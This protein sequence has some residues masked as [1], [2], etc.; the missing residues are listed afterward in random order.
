MQ[1][2][3]GLAR[4]RRGPHRQQLPRQQLRQQPRARARWPRRCAAAAAAPADQQQQ[5][6]GAASD[7]A[8]LPV[9]VISGFLGAGK[10]TL[11]RHLLSNTGGQ[12]VAVLVN[13]MAALNVDARLLADAAATGAARVVQAGGPP[14]LVALSNGCICCTIR[15]DLVREVRALAAQ[16][17]FDCLVIEST[18]ISLPMPVAATFAAGGDGDGG[19]SGDDPGAAAL[20]GLAG[21]ARL[22]TLVTVV[23][24]Q[25]FVADVLAAD[26]LAE[27]SLQADDGDER[28]VADLLVEQVEFAD[29]LL[30]NKTDLLTPHEQQQ[31][32][33]LLRK[34]NPGARVLLAERGRVPAAEVLRTGAFSLERAQAAAGWLQEINAFEARQRAA[35]AG[36][37]GG[38]HGDCSHDHGHAHEGSHAH[39]HAAH[40]GHAHDA[41]DPH[42]GEAARF[43]ISSFVYYAQR[44]FHPGRLLDRALSATW[45]GVLRSKGFFWL[46]TRHDVMGLWQSAGGAWQGEPSALWNAAAGGDAAAPESAPGG[47]WHPAWGD[48]CQELVWIG[49]GMDEP[50]LRAMLDGCL[51]TD[52]EMALGPDG[53]AAFDD[54]LPPWELGEEELEEGEELDGEL[55]EG[56][57]SEE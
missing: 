45:G 22:D 32:L 56:E 33:A 49:I 39:A 18:G 8:R 12:R 35:A 17:A 54:P 40:D 48:R 28:T 36:A 31:L 10:T 4:L 43:G 47:A 5:Q 30:L 42:D 3:Q 23:D 7:D 16:Q 9:T 20:G 27:R 1:A 37:A 34:L 26:L 13:D 44:P 14:A 25:R 21:V 19:D 6:P 57:E 52:D 15:E 29:V 11:L 46:A 2:P 53:W 50:G 55:E 51:L 41:H 38:G 24:G